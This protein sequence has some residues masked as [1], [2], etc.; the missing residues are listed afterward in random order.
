MNT[1]SIYQIPFLSYT[2][3]PFSFHTYI[4]AFSQQNAYGSDL[5]YLRIKRS[6]KPETYSMEV[7]RT[8]GSS[9][10]TIN[11]CKRF[12][13]EEIL[14]Y[15]FRHNIRSL[16]IFSGIQRLYVYPPAHS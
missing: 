12:R 3:K 10:G 8:M 4:A 11:T 13:T 16:W 5:V 7:S 14:W 15:I 2:A 9:A 1:T 6:N